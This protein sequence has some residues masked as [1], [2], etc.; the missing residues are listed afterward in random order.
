[1]NDAAP[2]SVTPPR[3]V[4]TDLNHPAHAQAVFEL[5]DHYA[6]DPMGGGAPL[7]AATRAVLVERLRARPGFVSF[8]AF[9]RD[10]N[11]S[12]DEGGGATRALGLLNA[13]EG[14]ST[15]AA[16]PLLNV[17]DI[18]VHAA[19]RGRGIARALLAAAEDAARAR[20]CCKLTLEV[21]SN[22][23]AALR[24]YTHA[25]FRPYEL[26]PAAGQALFLQK[27]L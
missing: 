9:E 10:H 6:R 5:L 8:L 7:P 23:T 19:H 16:Q 12:D 13:F 26:D 20:G 27:W 17:H 4:A 1:M 11:G 25:G 21:L 15:F 3:I 22:N 18:V 14:F 2:A 24:A